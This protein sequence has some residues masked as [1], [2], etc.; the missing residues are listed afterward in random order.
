[1]KDYAST[2][3]VSRTFISLGIIANLA[4]FANR[5][6]ITRN[7]IIVG[8]KHFST[9]LSSKNASRLP[10]QNFGAELAVGLARKKIGARF[11]STRTVR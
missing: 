2:S 7:E 9:K 10:V 4:K 3:F 5:K 1:M 11:R 8:A 6:N